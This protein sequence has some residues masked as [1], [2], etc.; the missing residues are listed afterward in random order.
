M[1]DEP[2]A[3][4]EAVHVQLVTDHAMRDAMVDLDQ[5]VRAD[6]TRRLR[7]AV[8]RD[9]AQV[10][11]TVTDEMWPPD[12]EPGEPQRLVHRYRAVVTS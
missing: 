4:V 1:T 10:S 8:G 11:I 2:Q 6:M 3:S 7:R 9:W 5:L 12:P